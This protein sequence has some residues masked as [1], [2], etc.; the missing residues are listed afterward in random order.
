MRV[1]PVILFTVFLIVLFSFA[2]FEAKDFA[3][4]GRLF[5]LIVGIPAIVLTLIQLFSDLRANHKGDETKPQDFVDIA[6]DLSIPWPVVRTRALRFLCWILGLYLAIWIVGFKIAIPLFFIAFMRLEGKARWVI[7]I[8]LTAV[9]VYVI[10]HY[11]EELLGVFW[12]QPLISRW[13][14]IP[15]LF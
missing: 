7:I 1:N 15:W 6:P 11:F 12:P 3:F 8:S 4:A 13:I 14:D 10:F 2:V 9:S 5:P